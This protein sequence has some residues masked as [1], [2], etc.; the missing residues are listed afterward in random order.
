[1]VS[2]GNQG[3]IACANDH[4]WN[5]ELSF[6]IMLLTTQIIADT[7]ESVNVN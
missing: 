5:A 3:F 6:P 2:T 1:M 4:E 7:I